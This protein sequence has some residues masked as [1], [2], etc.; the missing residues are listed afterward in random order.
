MVMPRALSFMK[1]TLFSLPFTWAVLALPALPLIWELW[2]NERYFPE[3][4]YESGL[5]SVQLLVLAL[6]ITPL[7]VVL[8]PAAVARSVV[9]FMLQRRRAV[10]VAAFGYGVLH[11]LFYVRQIAAL[12]LIWLEAL[13]G[14]LLTG[15]LALFA[16]AVG[17]VTSNRWSQI[18]LG[19]RWKGVQRTA[20]GAALL[21][22]LHWYWINQ[23]LDELWVYVVPL[24]AAQLVRWALRRWRG[25]ARAAF[26][27]E[28]G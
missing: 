8:K 11:T 13:Q 2:Q 3:L 19:S 26:A 17:A 9:R 20:Y 25:R 18:K 5:L 10:G 22:G 12:D 28:A 6:L 16:M 1:S 14:E 23:F 21:T 24:A 7:Q 4:M 27:N 15:W